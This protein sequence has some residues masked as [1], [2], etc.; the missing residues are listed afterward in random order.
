MEISNTIEEIYNKI[1][2]STHKGGKQKNSA[3]QES[4]IY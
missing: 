2:N 1:K 4:K 3:I